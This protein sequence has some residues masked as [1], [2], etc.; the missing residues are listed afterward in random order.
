MI[1]IYIKTHN[2]TGLKYLGKTTKDPFKYRGSGKYWK[3]Y[4]A[5]HGNNVTTEVI[6]EFLST[7][8][9]SA[10][11]LALSREWDSL[12]PMNGQIL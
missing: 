6:A 11:A 7:D 9:C 3:R 1:S 4:L 8:E 12:T 2:V 5:K 10:F